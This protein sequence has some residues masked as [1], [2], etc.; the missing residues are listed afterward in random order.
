M[1]TVAWLEKNPN[2]I[3]ALAK[4]YDSPDIA[5]PSGAMLR[6]CIRHENLNKLVLQSPIFYNYFKYVEVSN[7]DI[8]SDAFNTLKVRHLSVID[9][10]MTSIS[11]KSLIAR[12]LITSNRSC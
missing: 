6:E 2:I 5:L 4:G 12:S 7:F 1:V 11:P 9:I 3:Y 8:A 10:R